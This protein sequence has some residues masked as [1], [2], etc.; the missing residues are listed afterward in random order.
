ML[1]GLDIRG[2]TFNMI[3]SWSRRK[4]DEIVPK[5]EE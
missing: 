1:D 3:R 5:E 4:P 2:L